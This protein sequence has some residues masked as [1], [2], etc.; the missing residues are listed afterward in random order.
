M[1]L[2]GGEPKM[3]VVIGGGG[4]LRRTLITAGPARR[5]KEFLGCYFL[6]L[7][8]LICCIKSWQEKEG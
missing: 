2:S 5:K 4:V 8:K 3:D 7:I 6:S 1:Q